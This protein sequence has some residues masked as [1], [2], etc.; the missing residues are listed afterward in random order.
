MKI[1]IKCE[2]PFDWCGECQALDLETV[3]S[4]AEATG[5]ERSYVCRHADSCECGE[6]AAR[7]WRE[8]VSRPMIEI[9][10]ADPS[11][12]RDLAELIQKSCTLGPVV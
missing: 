9:T 11:K 2:L 5:P 7:R 10:S 12:R 1:D 3:D 4:Y 8:E 6:A